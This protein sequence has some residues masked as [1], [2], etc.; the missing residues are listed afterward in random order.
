ML[1][2]HKTSPQGQHWNCASMQAHSESSS[3]WLIHTSTVCSLT[4]ASSEES[5]AN[6]GLNCTEDAHIHGQDGF[7]HV[8]QEGWG[9]AKHYGVDSL[10]S[11]STSLQWISESK[12]VSVKSHHLFM[13]QRDATR[14]TFWVFDEPP[15]MSHKHIFWTFY[16]D[17]ELLSF[18][19]V[20]FFLP[21]TLTL[22]SY[23]VML[24]ASGLSVHNLFSALYGT[25]KSLIS[26]SKNDTAP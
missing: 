24:T 6:K 19:F 25:L 11:R 12:A 23:T 15:S 3:R 20:F 7:G 9:W 2:L 5:S 22:S 21:C 8:S 16:T 14:R 18:A 13:S 10:C 1:Q 17:K 4:M 26:F